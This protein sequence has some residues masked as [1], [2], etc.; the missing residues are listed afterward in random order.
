[1]TE[2]LRKLMIPSIIGISFFV[3][4]FFVVANVLDL[5][6]RE[7]VVGLIAGAIGGMTMLIA[8]L[9]QAHT[10]QPQPSSAT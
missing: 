6:L 8:V 5:A 1:M 10:E 7:I 4:G 9:H 3:F 2:D